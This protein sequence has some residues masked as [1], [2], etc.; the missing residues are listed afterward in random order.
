MIFNVKNATVQDQ[1]C[2]IPNMI[3]HCSL[4]SPVCPCV[5]ITVRDSSK[6]ESQRHVSVEEFRTAN[7]VADGVWLRVPRRAITTLLVRR[8]STAA[9]ELASPIFDPLVLITWRICVRC[10]PK[11]ECGIVTNALARI[12]SLSSRITVRIPKRVANPG[13]RSRRVWT[14][15]VWSQCRTHVVFCIRRSRCSW[16]AV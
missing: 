9:T 11:I 3:A 1:S 7:C 13:V 10:A 5:L 16:I 4:K 6:R 14:E 12:R 8:S 2:A 15:H